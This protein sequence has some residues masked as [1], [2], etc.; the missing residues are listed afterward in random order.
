MMRENKIDEPLRFNRRANMEFSVA[1]IQKINEGLLQ[2]LNE[3]SAWAS[4]WCPKILIARTA[5]TIAKTQ[6]HLFSWSSPTSSKKCELWLP[7]PGW[8]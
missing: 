7:N 2:A 3:N 8:R 5:P 4:L 6:S 1:G